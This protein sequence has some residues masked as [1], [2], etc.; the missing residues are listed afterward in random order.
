MGGDDPPQKS[1][2]DISSKLILNSVQLP[3]E[4]PDHVVHI[5]AGEEELLEDH[6]TIVLSQGCVRKHPVK[7]V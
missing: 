3:G 2:R 6:V 1:W 5:V 7:A 4:V